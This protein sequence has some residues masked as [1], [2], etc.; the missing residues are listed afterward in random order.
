MTDFPDYERATNAAYNVLQNYNYIFPKIDVYYI[1]DKYKNIKLCTYSKA[2]KNLEVTH[3]IFAYDIAS[4]EYGYTVAKCINNKFI[5]YYNNFKDETTIR[6]TL[7]H[8]LAHI[9]LQHTE[10]NDIANKEA[11]CFARNI[12]CPI[13]IIDEFKL[14]TVKD[15][16]ECFNISEPMAKAAIGHLKSD[17]YY[18]SK[19]LYNR[20]ND[21]IYCY[22]T[23]CTLA[24]L[25]GYA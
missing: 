18:I 25:Y 5:I 12:L 10:D 7:M 11:N 8:E 3:N 2:A 15:Y 24:E 13:Q 14:S 6:F 21:N 9:I 23:G 16:V 4:S 19:D 20:V 22:M 1:L 17:S